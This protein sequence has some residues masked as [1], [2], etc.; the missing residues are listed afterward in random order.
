MVL[1][2]ALNARLFSARRCFQWTLLAQQQIRESTQSI[3]SS[4]KTLL[5]HWMVIP[6]QKRNYSALQ[7]ASVKASCQVIEHNMCGQAEWCWPFAGM[8]YN[9]QK[10]ITE[11]T[12]VPN[13][14]FSPC[15][16]SEVRAFQHVQELGTL[17]SSDPGVAIMR[18]RPYRP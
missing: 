16:C 10:A 1:T 5:Q 14:C 2:Y 18:R 9:E 6:S 11:A 8:R 15:L 13:L 7:T 3:Y 12:Q 4:L 17:E